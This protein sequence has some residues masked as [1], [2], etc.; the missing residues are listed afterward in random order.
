MDIK[1]DRIIG[2][3]GG[4]GPQSGLALFNN[5]LHHTNAT[6]DQ[7][8]LSS[9]LISLP[10][11]IVD[12]TLFLEGEV[13]DNPAVN[14]VE[15]IKKLENTG[16]KIVGIACNTCHSPAIYN[17]ILEK[18][19]DINSQV[20]LINMPVEV[21]KYIKNEY[22][23]ARRIGLMTTNGTYKSKLYEDLLVSFG[24]EVIVPDYKFQNDVIHKIIY[25]PNFG[26]K[27]NPNN[28]AVEVKSLVNEA[29]SF[30]KKKEVDAIVLGCTELSLILIE[31]FRGNIPIVDST[32]ILARALIR[33][34]TN[35]PF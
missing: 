17:V 15:I 35:Q 31:D 26:I 13:K 32:E 23:H 21:C 6:T 33:E 25:D 9:I 14:I 34:A 2:I 19:D 24:Y 11:Y 7:Q 12:R 1:E 20:K 4:M 10:K 3:V 5:I 18:L 8:H 29:L 16:A 28:I 22:P 27:S 30:F